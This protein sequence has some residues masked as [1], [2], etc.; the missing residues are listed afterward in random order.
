MS[1]V[2]SPHLQKFEK[3]ILSLVPYASN[4]RLEYLVKKL[5]PDENSGQHLAVKNEIKKLA[6]QAN[7]PIDLRLIFADCQIVT[8]NKVNH[9]LDIAGKKLFNEKL[10]EYQNLYTTA[11]YY[12]VYEDAQKRAANKDKGV[13]KYNIENENENEND[14]EFSEFK[15]DKTEPKPLVNKNRIINEL[16]KLNSACKVFINPIMGMT[17]QG[18]KE[19]GITANIEKMNNQKVVIQTSHEIA[20][21]IANKVYLWLY[22]HH[23]EIDFTE[24]L[25]LGFVIIDSQKSSA[26]KFEYLLKFSSPLTDQ[27]MRV[28]FAHY[29][30]QKKLAIIGPTERFIT[31]LFDSVTSKGYEQLYLNKTHDIPL[32]CYKNNNAWHA[33]VAMKTSGNDEFWRFFSD[34]D[35]NFHL[36]VLLGNEDIQK[37]LNERNT[38]DKYAFILKSKYK[39]TFIYSLI[40]YDDFV[41]NRSVKA[42]FNNYFKN[43]LFRVVKIS[44]SFINSV[45]DAYVPSA[46]P[47]HV[48]PK[49]AV[50]NR[51][52]P[53]AALDMI[54]NCDHMITL[55]DITSLYETIHRP[56]SEDIIELENLLPKRFQLSAIDSLDETEIVTAENDDSRGED[57]FVLSFKMAITRSNNVVT[58]IPGITK[59]ISIQ[60]L[61]VSL[62]KETKF[63]AGEEIEIEL[64]VPFSEQDRTLQKQKYIVLGYDSHGAVRLLMNTI[65]SKHLACR[66]IR[67]YIYQHVDTLEA[68]GKRGSRI[69]GLQ[70]AMRNIYAHNHFSI[71]FYL[72][73]TKHQQYINAASFSGNSALKHLVYKNENSEEIILNLL[74]NQKF[75][76]SCLS[77][78]AV[79][80][81]KE[82]P[83]RAFYI[84]VLPKD[85]DDKEEYSFWYRD[86]SVLKKSAQLKEYTQKVSNHGKPAIL[87]VELKKSDKVQN[88][89][90]RD[91]ISYLKSLDKDLADDLETQL[92]STI[93][94]GEVTD[95]TDI[96]IK[97]IANAT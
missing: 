72:K 44:S 77:I 56:V 35:E 4:D 70:K 64:T 37:A 40:W 52:I 48:H 22:D 7:K 89:Y 39:D 45:E 13:S 68:C 26:N 28:L 57:R 9:Y 85:K 10:V 34:T 5:L 12:E 18:K 1:S 59:N 43:S 63:K 71:P 29:L 90:Y 78:I 92:E 17:A 55:S 69:Y 74:S 65:E 15:I 73:A 51:A 91:E 3:Q 94:I 27:Q 46:L 76:D 84:L 31:P 53:K 36:P 97:M 23:T 50:L 67:K 86:L 30:R 6:Q 38:V 21:V 54:S 16:K 93:G 24:E 80:A 87:K 49:M 47:C 19:V 88:M 20:G 11:L 58:H 25:E 2:I 62:V 81:Y 82:L 33:K 83:A 42:V 32:L 41:N 75:R 66:A 96:A 95:L 79:L 60:G 14:S 61:L 8:H